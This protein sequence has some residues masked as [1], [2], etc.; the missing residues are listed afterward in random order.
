MAGFGKVGQAVKGIEDFLSELAARGGNALRNFGIWNKDNKAVRPDG[1]PRTFY[2][3]VEKDLYGGNAWPVKILRGGPVD[4][5][6]PSLKAISDDLYN[7]AEARYNAGMRA[8]PSSSQIAD[9][10]RRH[11]VGFGGSWYSP[12]ER[13]AKMFAVHGDAISRG[14]FDYIPEVK[15]F[16]EGISSRLYTPEQ[17]ETYYGLLDKY[18]EMLG[19]VQPVFLQQRRPIVLNGRNDLSYS[20]LAE[21]DFVLPKKYYNSDN[22]P[23][24]SMFPDIVVNKR[25]EEGLADLLHFKNEFYPIYARNVIDDLPHPS[26]SP[27]LTYNDFDYY[28]YL[29]RSKGMTPREAFEYMRDS[30]TSLADE[31]LERGV[32]KRDWIEQAKK[33]GAFDYNNW[34]INRLPPRTDFVPSRAEQYLSEKAGDLLENKGYRDFTETVVDNIGKKNYG[35][36]VSMENLRSE[37]GGAPHS[38]NVT[39]RGPQAKSPESMFNF[40]SPNINYGW[41]AAPASGYAGYEVLSPTNAQAHVPKETALHEADVNPVESFTLGAL[42]PFVAGLRS[43]NPYVAL[44][45]G[46]VG[47][48]AGLAGDYTLTELL[49]ALSEAQQDPWWDFDVPPETYNGAM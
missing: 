46:V 27:R 35:D 26:I 1:M 3:G 48:T 29:I 9:A 15:A 20:E 25:Y 24:V 28:D 33:V 12:E 8:V 18:P 41:L 42:P 49:N 21:A 16:R 47:G 36:S 6:L 5:D 10:Y 22:M 37:H 30:Y 38:E 23:S 19:N 44:L 45:G 11:G 40:R 7:L 43:G 34:D 39:F 32:S 31:L 14:A 13:F 2:R 4:P 17:L